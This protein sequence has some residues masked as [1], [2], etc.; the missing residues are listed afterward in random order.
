[1]LSSNGNDLAMNE[2]FKY[3]GSIIQK[4]GNIE[5]DVAHR[6]ILGWLKWR[7]AT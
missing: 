2:C 7:A 5:Q 3:L 4:N 6:I 1:M